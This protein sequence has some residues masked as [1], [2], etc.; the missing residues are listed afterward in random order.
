MAYSIISITPEYAQQIVSWTYDPPYNLYDLAS[1]DLS[2]LL[3]PDYRYHVVL[4]EEGELVGY[5]CFGED[6]RVPGGDFDQGEPGILDLGVGLSPDLTSQGFGK[7]FVNAILKYGSQTY[8]PEVFRVTVAAFNP[9]SLRT[10]RALGFKDKVSFTRTLLELEF[11][12][13]E[14]PILGK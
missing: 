13:L 10:F 11:I 4:N 7:G 1:D 14:K 12:Q 5:C 9:R 3:N 6:A 2:G 8:K